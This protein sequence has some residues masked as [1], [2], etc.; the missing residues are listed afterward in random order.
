MYM[1]LSKVSISVT[2]I[3][4][5]NSYGSFTKVMEIS[6]SNQALMKIYNVKFTM[7]FPLKRFLLDMSKVVVSCRIAQC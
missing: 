6:P 4:P 2:T 7:S 5:A 1:D 3:H